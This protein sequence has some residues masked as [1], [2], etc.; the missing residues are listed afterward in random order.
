MQLTILSYITQQQTT[1]AHV[2]SADKFGGKDEPAAE[3]RTQYF[4]VFASC[5]AAEKDH[6]TIG[7]HSAGELFGGAPQ[8]RTVDL[9]LN[10]DR[11][12]GES[13][14]VWE[15]NQSVMR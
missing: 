9:V 15:L 2:P 4:Y 14:Q 6:F 10:L 3:N 11:H 13:P 5:E 1:A 12:G 8:R 7:T